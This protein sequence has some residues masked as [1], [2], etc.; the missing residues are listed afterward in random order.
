MGGGG[1]VKIFQLLCDLGE[2]YIF[3]GFGNVF[4][5]QQKEGKRRSSY[6]DKGFHGSEGKGEKTGNQGCHLEP[7]SAIFL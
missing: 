4:V 3:Q 1:G 7:C 2:V 5:S 6:G